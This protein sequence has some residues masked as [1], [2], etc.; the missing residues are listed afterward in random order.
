MDWVRFRQA[1]LVRFGQRISAAEADA[2]LKDLRQDPR[3]ELQ[4]LQRQFD[5]YWRQLEEVTTVQHG[6][7][8]KL[9]RCLA[10]L[11]PKVREKVDLEGPTT[12]K[13]L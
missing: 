1:F 3:E 11:H 5:A 12:L 2:K 4:S 8:F 6:N 10:C 7:H 13:K 9:K